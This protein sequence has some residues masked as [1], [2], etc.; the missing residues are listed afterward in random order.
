MPD[1]VECVCEG[2]IPY[3]EY[4]KL[5]DRV[6]ILVDQTYGNGWGMN[7]LIGAM[8]GKCVLAP[9]GLENSA[10]MGIPDIPFVQIGPDSELIYQ[11]LRDLVLNPDKIDSIKVSSRNFVEKYCNS[12]IIA[13]RYIDL[14]VK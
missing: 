3:D 7:A 6:D 13:R 5:F 9:C 12:D 4:V 8:K 1:R 2:G 10:N 14:V 11:T